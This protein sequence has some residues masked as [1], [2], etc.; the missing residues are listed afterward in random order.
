MGERFSY[1]FTDPDLKITINFS[2]LE[3][4]LLE[5]QND[6]IDETARV[7]CNLFGGCTNETKDVVVKGL[8]QHFK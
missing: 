5:I 6:A 7:M 8:K 2:E 3:L 4:L 1:P